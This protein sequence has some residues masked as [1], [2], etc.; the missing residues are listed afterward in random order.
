MDNKDYSERLSSIFNAVNAYNNRGLAYA[1]GIMYAKEGDYDRA[2][3]DFATVLR[4][5]PTDATAKNNLE[6]AREARGY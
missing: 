6:A 1:R 2:I 4:I 3:E 5:D